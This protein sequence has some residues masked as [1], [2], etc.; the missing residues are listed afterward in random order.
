M[1]LSVL[2]LVSAS[3]FPGQLNEDAASSN[4]GAAWVIDGATDLGPPELLGSSGAAWLSHEVSTHF[5]RTLIDSASTAAAVKQALAGVR[6][7]F[8]AA[9]RREPVDQWELPFAAFMMARLGPDHIEFAW[10][11]DCVALIR[12]L[13]GTVARIGEQAELAAAESKEAGRFAPLKDGHGK[14]LAASSPTVAH[15][16]AERSRKNREPDKWLLG[17]EPEAADYL[18]RATISL[19]QCAHILLM[20]DGLSAYVD[21]YGLGSDGALFD[22][23]LSGD[24]LAGVLGAVREVERNDADC[25]RFPRYK[26]SD[27]ATGILLAM[28]RS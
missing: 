2:D 19:T 17:V 21:R 24:G 9:K 7:R 20:T 6:D 23:A 26:A 5:H 22:R 13:D 14:M 10:L 11:A 15:L 3:A 25:V 27:D 18:N 8:H 16:R 4:H 12:N 28:V 1:R